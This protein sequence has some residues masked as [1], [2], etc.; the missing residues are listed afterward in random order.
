VADWTPTPLADTVALGPDLAPVRSVGV[1]TWQWGDRHIWHYGQEFGEQDVRGA[2]EAALASGLNLFDTAEI[3][4]SGQSERLLGRCLRTSGAEVVVATKFMPYPWR[5]GRAA[6]P[7]ALEGSL[8]RLVLPEVGLYQVHMPLPPVSIETWAEAL[9]DAVGL[10]LARAVGVSNYSADQMRHTHAVLARRGVRLVSNQIEYSLLQRRPERDGLLRTCHELGV[11]LIAYSPL[12][13]GL[14]GGRYTRRRPPSLARRLSLPRGAW[15][16]L[17]D[18]LGL[19][20][21][22]GLEQGGKTP[23]QVALNWLL[24][25]GALPIP[26]AKNARQVKENAGALGW[27][28]TDAQVAAL[29]RATAD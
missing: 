7:R 22:V 16:H 2:F 13:K 10:G 14:L 15:R 21:K 5:L 6:L 27:R 12:A 25:K 4:G 18:L 3:Y 29:D 17:P 28:L 26:G 20:H 1:G 23:A 19:L 8:G 24:C 9:A 11:Q